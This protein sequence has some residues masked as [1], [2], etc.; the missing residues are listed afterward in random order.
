MEKWYYLNASLEKVGPISS[1]A[2]KLLADSGVIDP[3]TTLISEDGTRMYEAGDVGG[4]FE[5]VDPFASETHKREMPKHTPPTPPPT[6]TSRVPPAPP[7]FPLPPPIQTPPS[8]P[9]VWSS[10]IAF[11]TP[12]SSAGPTVDRQTPSAHAV[13]SKGSIGCLGGHNCFG[14][15][16]ALIVLL[17]VLLLLKVGRVVVS[18]TPEPT[19]KITAEADQYQDS[20]EPR[21]LDRF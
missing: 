13:A 6:S 1:S 9:D 18:L 7:P 16:I 2:L 17:L 10:G 4:L 21:P 11:P 20:S 3:L 19:A 8:V 12:L 14:F 15:I 5:G